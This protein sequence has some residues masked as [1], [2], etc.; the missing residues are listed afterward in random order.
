MQQQT[1]GIDQEDSIV[2][3]EA[4][5]QSFAQVKHSVLSNHQSQLLVQREDTAHQRQQVR[6]IVHKLIT[7]Q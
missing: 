1:V 5:T 3:K 2:Q 6:W 7:V 4:L